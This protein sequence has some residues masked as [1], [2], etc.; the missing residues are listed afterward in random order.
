MPVP[1]CARYNSV[2]PH[3]RQEMVTHMAFKGTKTRS[4]LE[5]SEAIEDVGVVFEC[6]YIQRVYRPFTPKCLK[7]TWNSL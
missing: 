5:I 7:M 2:Y 4:A 3:W 6:L 1:V